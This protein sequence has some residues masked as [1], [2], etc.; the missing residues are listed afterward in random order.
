MLQGKNL[1]TRLID[2][3]GGWLAFVQGAPL[4]NNQS[5]QKNGKFCIVLPRT[6][7]L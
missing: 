7:V 5:E 1:R 4:S 2:H 3:Q 6:A